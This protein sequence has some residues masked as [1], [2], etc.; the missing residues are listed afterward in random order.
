VGSIGV[1]S[2]ECSAA[3]PHMF[4]GGGVGVGVG[5]GGEGAAVAAA[6][7]PHRAALAR[8]VQSCAVATF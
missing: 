6:D 2:P 3:P 7:A 4:A 8:W 1:E 5:V